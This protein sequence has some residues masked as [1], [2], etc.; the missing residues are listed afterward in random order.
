MVSTEMN[1]SPR[2]QTARSAAEV[3]AIC[4]SENR[5]SLMR[6]P[7]LAEKHTNGQRSSSALA[8]DGEAF[9]DHRPHRTAHER[10]VERGGDRRPFS[11]PSIAIS[12]SR[13]P[14]DV[15]R[16][17][18]PV[19]ILL[20]VLE[21]EHVG[22]A[23]FGAE[24]A[25]GIRSSR[26]AAA[27]R[28]R[29]SARGARTSGKPRGFPRAPA[30]VQDRAAR[31]RTFPTGLRHAALAF[32]A[33]IG[34]DARGMGQLFRTSP[35][36]RDGLTAIPAGAGS[37]HRSGSGGDRHASSAAR[38]GRGTPRAAWRDLAPSALARAPRPARCRRPRRPCAVTPAAEAAS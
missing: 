38:S 14:L 28:A 20:L 13:S 17:L 32:R 36:R 31:C 24:F 6:A 27:A 34:A 37:R 11:L 19:G 9:A 5:L 8:G 35:G 29:G 30:A 10:E 15:L 25:G 18:D 4:I 2:A 1:G 21:L 26:K 16:G 33:G 7:P 22:R 3:L 23:E 12:A